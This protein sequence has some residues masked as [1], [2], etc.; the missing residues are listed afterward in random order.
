VPLPGGSSDKYG[1]RYED[2]WAA[3][4][5]FDILRERASAIRIEPP[6]PE[7]DG[8]EFWVDYPD[9]RE[10][11]QVKRQLTREGR[12]TLGALQSVGVLARTM[13]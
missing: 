10:Y 5:A 11:H 1:N 4:C 12:W 7:G 8:V 6:G 3:Q 13:H 9:R 2:R